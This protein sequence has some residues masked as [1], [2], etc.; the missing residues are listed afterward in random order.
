MRRLSV[1]GAASSASI[2]SRNSCTSMMETVSSDAHCP[3]Q[4]I[5][6]NCTKAMTSSR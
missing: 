2:D 3:G 4:A 5:P 6:M 1:F